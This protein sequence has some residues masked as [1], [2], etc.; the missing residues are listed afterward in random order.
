MLGIMYVWMYGWLIGITITFRI[1]FVIIIGILFAYK[2]RKRNVKLLYYFATAFFCSAIVSLPYFYDF[3]TILLTDNNINL[4][5]AL[6]LGIWS[7]IIAGPYLVILI[8]VGIE[9]L[10]RKKNGIY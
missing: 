4:S 1:I 9:L 7:F 3:I 5:L 2:A 10:L 6:D 8:Y